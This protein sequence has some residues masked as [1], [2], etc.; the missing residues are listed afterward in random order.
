M[1]QAAHEDADDVITECSEKM[2]G[3]LKEKYVEY[4]DRIL[5]LVTADGVYQ[6]QSLL[7][8]VLLDGQVFLVIN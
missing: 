4:Y 2:K 3:V 6:E 7:T 8:F 5:Q 1:S